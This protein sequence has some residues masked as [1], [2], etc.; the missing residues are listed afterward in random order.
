M[1]RE[2]IFS[3][4]RNY[5]R[6]NLTDKYKIKRE[7]EKL[8]Q[9]MQKDNKLKRAESYRVFQF[10]QVLADSKLFENFIVGVIVFNTVILS[11]DKY[12]EQPGLAS[13]S[14]KTNLVCSTLFLLEM[15]IRLSALGFKFYFSDKYN[16]LDALV[17]ILSV[18]D[19]SVN[20]SIA[21]ESSF[22]G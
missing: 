2:K 11:L 13:F 4:I 3:S 5:M 18:T 8:L 10:C 17:V 22:A 21:S 15:L 20:Y 1:I 19:I 16:C 12:P 7:K 6:I 14:E 9:S